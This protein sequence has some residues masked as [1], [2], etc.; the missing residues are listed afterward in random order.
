[1][2]QFQTI[3]YMDKNKIIPWII[4][5]VMVIVFSVISEGY[6]LIF[7]FVP[8]VPIALWLYFKTCYKSTS[9]VSI[10][11]YYL[12][13]VGFQFIHFAEEH[14]FGFER[15]FGVLFG[16]SPY[17]HNTFVTFNMFAY[18]LFILGGIAFYK[19][20]KPLQMFAMFFI[21]Y[22]MAG[23]AI[24]HIVFCV[25]AKGYFPGIYTS[26]LNLI[27]FPFL[28]AELIKTKKRALEEFS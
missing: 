26:F 20:W 13:G 11:P 5:I 25:M 14:A 9:N 12:L 22:G 10:L 2:K 21:V 28:L 15:Q 17:D 6:S 3:K 16:G 18:L 19:N 4:A 23:N 24:G 8:A 1:M 27:L 7:T